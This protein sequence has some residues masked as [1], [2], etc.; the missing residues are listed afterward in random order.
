MIIPYGILTDTT[1]VNLRKHI[2][3]NHSLFMVDAFPERDNANRRVFEDVKMST[4]ILLTSK[5]KLDNSFNIGISYDRAIS[6]NR[7]IFSASELIQLNPDLVQIPLTNTNSFNLLIK[8]YNKKETVKFGIISPCLT[9]EIDMTFGKPALSNNHTDIM[10]IKGVQLDRYVLKTKKEQI[11]QGEIEFINPTRL[12]KIISQKKLQDSSQRRIALQG[13]TGVNETRRLK[14]TLID[15]NIFLANSSNYLLEPNNC[16][17]ELMLCWLNSKLLN[18]VFKA[19]STSSNVNG[20]EVD[21][22]PFCFSE[23]DEK[24]IKLSKSII[25]QKRKNINENTGEFEKEI[26]Q[27][28]YQLYDLTEEEIA[29]VENA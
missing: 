20:Y 25:S 5:A 7:S 9:G 2:F 10:L 17:L 28:I 24:L 21:N 4:A 3:S 19:R 15:E 22:L 27:L 14:A 18:F 12:S 13:L 16:N 26:D 11:S 23:Y 29:I 8:I 6:S 1:S